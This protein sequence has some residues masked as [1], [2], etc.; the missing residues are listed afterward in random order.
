MLIEETIRANGLR[1]VEDVAH[2]TKAGGGCASCHE[3]IEEI[4]VKVLAEQ[5]EAFDPHAPSK[6]A[7][8]PAKLTN[9]Q[10]IRRIEMIIE[11]LRPRLQMDHG[12]VELVD[13]DGKHVFVN[14]KGACSGCQMASATLG[15]IQQQLVEELGE[16]VQVLPA[17]ARALVV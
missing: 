17:D 1:T 6:T 10:R 3:G 13:V 7:A 16:F 11:S 8:K 4:L 14:M 2:Y 5:G 9:L 12:D 15:G